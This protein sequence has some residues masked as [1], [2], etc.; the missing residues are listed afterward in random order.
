MFG[1]FILLGKELIAICFFLGQNFWYEQD[2]SLFKVFCLVILRPFR[3]GVLTIQMIVAKHPLPPRVWCLCPSLT[4]TWYFI[5]QYL[6]KL[7]HLSLATFRL[8]FRKT[9]NGKKVVGMGKCS[10]LLYLVPSPLVFQ[11]R[12]FSVA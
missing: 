10:C 4:F 6:T 11:D 9:Y 3:F 8:L 12:V 1:K 2:P 7:T 5:K